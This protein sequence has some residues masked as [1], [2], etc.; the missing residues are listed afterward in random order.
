MSLKGDE[1]NDLMSRVGDLQLSDRK[2]LGKQLITGLNLRDT[3][4]LYGSILS[5]IPSEN[6]R[7]VFKEAT[8]KLPA[9]EKKEAAKEVVS[10]LTESDRKEVLQ[11]LGVG[12]PGEKTRD[13]LWLI[14]VFAFAI[15]L[16]GTFITLALG[17]FHAPEKGASTKPELVLTMFTSVVGFLAGLFVPSPANRQGQR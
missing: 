13:S 8:Q 12:L 10:Q 5:D 2:S 17:V 4:D 3:G 1:L 16:V 11:Q 9:D 14:V 7:V 15:V 6:A